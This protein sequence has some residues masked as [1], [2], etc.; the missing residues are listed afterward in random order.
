MD[1]LSFLK[2][3]HVNFIELTYC[4]NVIYG[5]SRKTRMQHRPTPERIEYCYTYNDP[6]AFETLVAR[7]LATSQ[8]V[9]TMLVSM[10]VWFWEDQRGPLRVIIRFPRTP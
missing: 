4:T 7:L 2:S 9:L 1:C 3:S 10:I 5:P 6:K 8:G